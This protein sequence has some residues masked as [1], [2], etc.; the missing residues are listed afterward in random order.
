[1]SSSVDTACPDV[2]LTDPVLLAA[3]GRL[4]PPQWARCTQQLAPEHRYGAY[5]AGLAAGAAL[6]TWQLHR[7]EAAKGDWEVRPAETRMLLCLQGGLATGVLAASWG[8]GCCSTPNALGG[9]CALA[10]LGAVLNR[11]I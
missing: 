6:G 5:A 3:F 8:G 9:A 2:A 7:H 10:V 4:S 1:M 11:F